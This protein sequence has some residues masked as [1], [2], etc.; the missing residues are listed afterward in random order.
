VAALS[1]EE[2][3]EARLPLVGGWG[4][5]LDAVVR[6]LL[7]LASAEAGAKTL[8]FSEWH[9]V[10]RVLKAALDANNLRCCVA[11]GSSDAMARAL[12]AFRA[13]GGPDILLLPT[14]RGCNGL[15]L[16][17]ASHVIIVEPQLDVGAELQAVKRVDRIGQTRRT[18]VHRF[19]IRGSVEE[20]VRDLRTQAP[21][22]A[23]EA[24]AP[25]KAGITHG[26]RPSQ[27]AALLRGGVGMRSDEL[28]LDAAPPATDND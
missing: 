12:A 3:G 6:R 18:A 2:S 8:V 16:V 21:P 19:T 4:T 1:H 5:K 25:A 13:P 11:G 24:A 28:R 20:N 23:A 15:T 9:D 26:L 10:L 14:S 7:W 17:E 22:A 27:V